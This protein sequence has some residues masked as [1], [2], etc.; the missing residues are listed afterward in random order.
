MNDKDT[1][2]V[3]RGFAIVAVVAYHALTKLTNN[4]ILDTTEQLIDFFHVSIFFLIAGFLF[5]KNWPK[6]AERG[7]GSFIKGKIWRIFVPYYLSTVFFSLGIAAASHFSML[8]SL[9]DN[10]EYQVKRLLDILLDPLWYHKPLFRSLWFSWC[11]FWFF[12]VAWFFRPKWLFNQKTLLG[13]LAGSFLLSCA[14]HIINAY[15]LVEINYIVRRLIKFYQYFYLG[16][17]IYGRFR[18]ELPV[19]GHVIGCAVAGVCLVAARKYFVPLLD[20][21]AFVQLI[22]QAESLIF[23]V[24]MILLLLLLARKLSGVVKAHFV[25]LGNSSYTVYLLNSPWIIPIIA[26]LTKKFSVPS[27]IA[28]LI[29]YFCG[30]YLS[31]LVEK[32]YQTFM[33]KLR[34]HQKE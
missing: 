11:L 32:F 27:A 24:C 15:G 25:Q 3:M 31:I 9:L 14:A 1:L 23:A 20:Q 10:D 22:D 13:V 29:M 18:L 12:I 30:M 8:A 33:A 28:F 34:S 7:F 26:S 5:E 19:P 21:V 4:F 16:Q 2:Q 17:Y 6:Y